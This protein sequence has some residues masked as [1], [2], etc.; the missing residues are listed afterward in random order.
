MRP[1]PNEISQC[2]GLKGMELVTAS[3]LGLSHLWK[4]KFKPSFQDT[5]KLLCGYSLDHGHIPQCKNYISLLS[6]LSGIQC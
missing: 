6:P 1:L 2:L 4:H 5:L 3:R